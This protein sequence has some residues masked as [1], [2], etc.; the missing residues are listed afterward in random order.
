MLV[1]ARQPMGY[2]SICGKRVYGEYF[3][4]GRFGTTEILHDVFR[5]YKEILVEAP[6]TSDWL[7]VRFDTEFPEVSFTY[8]KMHEQVSFDVLVEVAK[9][10]GIQY[11]K[12]G[13]KPTKIEKRAL[14]RAIIKAIDSS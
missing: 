13:R 6:I 4:Y 9:G 8:E 14:R 10:I 3:S 11:I 7:S 5:K 2:T 12:G 1:Y